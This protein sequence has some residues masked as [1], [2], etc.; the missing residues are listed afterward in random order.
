MV[1][2]AARKTHE[3]LVGT[4]FIGIVGSLHQCPPGKTVVGHA[5]PVKRSQVFWDSNQTSSATGC[6]LV[7]IIIS[8]W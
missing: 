8:S 4:N 1:S 2:E 3:E 7:R 5:L 6:V